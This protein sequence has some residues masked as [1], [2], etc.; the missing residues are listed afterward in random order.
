MVYTLTGDSQ[1]SGQRTHSHCVGDGW[2]NLECGEWDAPPSP[3]DA[4]VALSPD[5]EIKKTEGMSWGQ[6]EED[7]HQDSHHF[8]I[9][10]I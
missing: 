10:M 8:A 2:P 6:T 3:A 7:T 9:F 1:C 4:P 5:P